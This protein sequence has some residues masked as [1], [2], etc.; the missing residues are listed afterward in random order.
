MKGL[1][2]LRDPSGINELTHLVDKTRPDNVHSPVNRLSCSENTRNRGGGRMLPMTSQRVKTVSH[3]DV[4]IGE[5]R[6][7]AKILEAMANA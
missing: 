7:A 6:E 2:P 4:T 1:S 3:L 5:C